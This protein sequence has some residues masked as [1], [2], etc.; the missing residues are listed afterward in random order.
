MALR[1]N[2][3][4]VAKKASKKKASKQKYQRK[5]KRAKKSPIVGYLGVRVEGERTQFRPSPVGPAAGPDVARNDLDHW[6]SAGDWSKYEV[7]TSEDGF[8]FVPLDD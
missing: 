7:R 5:V 8:E 4:K 1:K 6:C 3:G 2:S